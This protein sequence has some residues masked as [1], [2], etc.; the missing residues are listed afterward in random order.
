MQR[1]RDGIEQCASGGDVVV[2]GAAPDQQSYRFRMADRRSRSEVSNRRVGALTKTCR[3][4]SLRVGNNRSAGRTVD[5]L[6]GSEWVVDPGV[7]QALTFANSS[8]ES[9]LAY[10]AG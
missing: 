9:V 1:L 2:A 5:R 3:E 7:M 4:T 6:I 8:T 10:P